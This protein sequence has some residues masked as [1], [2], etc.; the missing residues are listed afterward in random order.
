M[1][2]TFDSLLGKGR[3]S[4]KSF[5]IGL[6]SSMEFNEW[7]ALAHFKAAMVIM[8]VKVSNA[9]RIA[10]AN[11]APWL[12]LNQARVLAKICPRVESFLEW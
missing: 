6:R 5:E 7:A 10:R 8:H 1:G 3:A 12:K 11:I 4:S 9:L 2:T